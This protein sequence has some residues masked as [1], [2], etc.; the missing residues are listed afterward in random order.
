[1]NLSSHNK[2]QLEPTKMNDVPMACEELAKSI[3]A[4][5]E[6]LSQFQSRLRLVSRQEPKPASSDSLTRQS[7]C[8]L[9]GMIRAQVSRIEEMSERIRGHSSVLEL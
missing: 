5:D 8:E 4:L 3:S 2:G 6:V 7:G 1:M 9:G